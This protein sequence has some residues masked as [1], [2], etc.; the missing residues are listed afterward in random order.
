MIITTAHGRS[1]GGRYICVSEE[2][3]IKLNPHESHFYTSGQLR[4][5]ISERVREL[6]PSLIVDI[7]PTSRESLEDFASI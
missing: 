3:N 4:K 6:Y 1:I 7:M 5:F 2:G